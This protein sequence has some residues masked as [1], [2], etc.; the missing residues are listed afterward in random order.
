[1]DDYEN[2]LTAQRGDVTTNDDNFNG[3]ADGEFSY[4]LSPT[5]EERNDTQ[6]QKP[7]D[8]GIDIEYDIH[9]INH[10]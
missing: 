6:A 9:I 3:I 7:T 8:N 5:N 4:L 1:M 10:H 2:P